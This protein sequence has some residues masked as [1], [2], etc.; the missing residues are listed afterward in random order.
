MENV[1]ALRQSDVT[2]QMVLHEAQKSAMHYEHAML[3]MIDTEGGYVIYGTE[4]S[5]V[6]ASYI[7][8]IIDA[9]CVKA[10]NKGGK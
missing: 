10:I 1:Y 9:R 4:M 8:K 5:S 6:I 3:I 7:S 2:P